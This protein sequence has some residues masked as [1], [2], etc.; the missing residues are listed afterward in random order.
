M[1]SSCPDREELE[2]LLAGQL[3]ALE[4]ADLS[5]HVESCPTCQALLQQLTD[6]GPDDLFRR[7][8]TIHL[9]G[10]EMAPLR[11]RW[12]RPP[13][14]RPAESSVLPVVPG[15]E[16][17]AE[18]GRGGMGV[19]YRARHLGL[20]RTVALKMIVAGSAAGKH[21]LARFRVEAAAVSRLRHPHIVQVYDAGEVHGQPYL[22]LEYV[23]GGSLKDHLDGTPMPP[24]AAAGL[25]ETLARAI[26]H[27]HQAGIVHRDL[28]PANVLLACSR[29][30]ERSVGP[31]RF[32]EPRLNQ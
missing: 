6:P 2:R 8:S 25:I 18:V 1:R 22:S 3:G 28:K 14:V 10:Y 17:D 15:Y 19:I 21:A 5:G 32:S 29:D 26:H 4:D 7:G 11:P 23:A 24:D 13:T 12:S 9:D 16:V 31:A 27:A 20:N 30:A